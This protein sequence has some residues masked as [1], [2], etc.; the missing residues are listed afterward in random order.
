MQVCDRDRPDV[1]LGVRLLRVL[2]RPKWPNFRCLCV[3]ID[4]RPQQV[5]WYVYRTTR[6]VTQAG[7]W[8]YGLF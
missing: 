3:D 5:Y 2:K 8:I 1:A 7:Q 4:A 6:P